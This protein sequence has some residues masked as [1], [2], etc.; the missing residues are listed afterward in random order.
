MG[1]NRRMARR[2]L[3]FFTSFSDFTVGVESLNT[4]HFRDGVGG[5]GAT[6]DSGVLGQI[7]HFI[8]VTVCDY[9]S[10]LHR[11]GSIVSQQ[12]VL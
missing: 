8:A 1:P 4:E 10:S 7:W 3:G 11:I 9:G 6:V 12:S 5:M 2:D